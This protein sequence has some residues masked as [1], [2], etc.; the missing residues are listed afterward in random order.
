M[1]YKVFCLGRPQAC[2]YLLTKHPQ[3]SVLP[4]GSEYAFVEKLVFFISISAVDQ[5]LF[6]DI[7]KFILENGALFEVQCLQGNMNR[8]PSQRKQRVIPMLQQYQKQCY[9][10]SIGQ[11]AAL[12]NLQNTTNCIIC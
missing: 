1:A 11:V 8:M 9:Q 12:Q 4:K 5:P 6:Y 7:L 2:H 10:Y 3:L